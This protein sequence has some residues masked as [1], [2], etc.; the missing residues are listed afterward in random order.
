MK[1]KAFTLIETMIV[2]VII[3][4]LATVLLQS[5]M[6]I[7]KIAFTVEQEKNLSEESLLLTQMIQ[8]IT[9]T[10]TIDY[11]RYK[12]EGPNLKSTNG[13]TEILYLTGGQRTGTSISFSG[14]CLPLEGA[15]E[16][17]DGM[18]PD[19]AELLYT[20][21]GCQIILASPD[22]KKTPLI[23][24]NK[25]ITSKV[26]FKV[27]PFDSEEHYFFNSDTTN[28]TNEIAKPGFWMFIHLYSPFYQPI[29]SNKIDLPLQ[30]FFNLNA[31]IP[32][33]I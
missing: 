6:T 29:G 21:S 2:L 30:L 20:Y 8:S 26:E 13:Y 5:Y 18:Y 23:V 16:T 17:K 25:L 12:N 4:I 9:D 14:E 15:F 33:F 3:G 7:T 31:P 11:E 22:G 32:S 27:I 28:V 19:S 24:T 10:A 1:T